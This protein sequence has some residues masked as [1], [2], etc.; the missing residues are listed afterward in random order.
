MGGLLT[1][2]NITAAAAPIVKENIMTR[3]IQQ[4]SR[5]SLHEAGFTLLREMKIID[6]VNVLVM[7]NFIDLVK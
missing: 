1:R 3:L 4:L 2:A 5:S 6:N 7:I